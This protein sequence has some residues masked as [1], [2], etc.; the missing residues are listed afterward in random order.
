MR[1]GGG[2]FFTFFIYFMPVYSMTGYGSA[3]V[4]EPAH[5]HEQARRCPSIAVEL[6][7]VN[8]R[9]LDLSFKLPDELRAHEAAARELLVG[10]FRRGKVE[11][12]AS[13]ERL[14]P[15][16]ATLSAPSTRSLHALAQTQSAVQ[17]VLP[18]ASAISVYE[19][20]RLLGDNQSADGG[21]STNTVAELGEPFLVAARQAA[22]AM[23]ASREREGAKLCEIL[24]ACCAELTALAQ[25]AK[26]LIPALVAQQ[27][28]KYLERF[29]AALAVQ[30][31]AALVNATAA[32]ER[33]LQE[34]VAYALRIDVA[35]ELTRLSAHLSE[36]AQLLA[37]GG[38]LGKRLDFVIQELHREANTLGSKS[39]TLELS[40]ISVDMKVL[41]EQM[42]EQVQNIE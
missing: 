31:G 15:D 34:A 2:N 25:R 27:Q 1:S 21:A 38:E 35:E 33:A 40:R 10:L 13:M 22:A 14:N 42:R 6:R 17:A 5:S 28:A 26:P 23:L 41:I 24:L 11:L 3:L 4:A 18:N 16:G 8:N 29:G 39:S 30:N 9:F 12:R 32:Q 19:A 7:S 36:I 20:L 37:Q